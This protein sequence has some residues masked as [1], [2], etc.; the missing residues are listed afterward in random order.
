VLAGL[1]KHPALVADHAERIDALRVADRGL[2]RLRGVLLD[3]AFAGQ[4]L[5]GA[6]LAPILV[7]AGLDGVARDIGRMNG[8]AF[9]FLRDNADPE[10][11][12][13]DL[14]EAIEALV[15]RPEIDAALARASAR[16]GERMDEAAYAEQQRLRAALR[17][18]ERRLMDL[19]Q[20]AEANIS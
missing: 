15:A 4:L 11:A 12:R 1:I 8:L 2:D 6:S 3:A 7:D 17:D 9:S 18:T 13:R 20:E 5:E 14:G 10:R 19:V 16:L